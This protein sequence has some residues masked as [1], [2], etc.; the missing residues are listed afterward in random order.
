ME[1]IE[2]QEDQSRILSM[3]FKEYGKELFEGDLEM[4]Q[5]QDY[6]AEMPPL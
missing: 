5:Q 2:Q 6:V 3:S 1:D 4:N